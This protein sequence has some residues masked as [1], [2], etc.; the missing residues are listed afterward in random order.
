MNVR[1][2]GECGGNAISAHIFSG[3]I[4]WCMYIYIEMLSD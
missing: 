1:G 4:F 3:Q 2:M